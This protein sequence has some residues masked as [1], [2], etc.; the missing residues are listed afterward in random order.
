M[1]GAQDAAQAGSKDKARAQFAEAAKSFP[2]QK[3]PWAKLAE[4]YFE[5]A[6][7]GNAILAAQEVV[8]RD[9]VDR[10]AHSILAVAG[11][12]VAS[13]SLVS[14]RDQQSGMP[15][16]TQSEARNLT[17]AL[18]ET[19][20]EPLLV[21]PVQPPPAVAA[22][23]SRSSKPAAA[24]AGG[25]A[26]VSTAGA[27]PAVAGASVAPVTTGSPVPPPVTAAPASLAAPAASTAAKAP[28]KAAVPS[29]DKPANP[30]DRLR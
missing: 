17:K 4:D 19:L 14:L 3:E 20:G 11:L 26:K 25:P 8:Q 30:F 1:K 22:R 2:T 28:V 29:A 7:Y 21:P 15:T 6:D 23:A 12:R 16:D 5:A 13:A 27:T 9:P 18:R 24:T 10:T